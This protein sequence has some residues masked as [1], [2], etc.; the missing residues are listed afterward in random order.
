[1]SP[2]DQGVP[3]RQAKDPQVALEQGNGSAPSSQI[4][5]HFETKETL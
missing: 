2:L 4:T 3:A 5:A 1:M